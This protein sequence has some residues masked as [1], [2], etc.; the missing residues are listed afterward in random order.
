MTGESAVLVFTEVEK[1]TFY[2]G[3][4]LADGED[5]AIVSASDEEIRK[6]AFGGAPTVCASWT[7]SGPIPRCAHKGEQACRVGGYPMADEEAQLMSKLEEFFW[8]RF[9]VKC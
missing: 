2:A 9:E 3:T 6:H 1:A 4:M 7:P 8:A 5:I